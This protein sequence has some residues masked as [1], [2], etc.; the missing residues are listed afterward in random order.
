[1]GFT[2]D[3][4]DQLVTYSAMTQLVCRASLVYDLLVRES[5]AELRARIE[6]KF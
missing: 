2:P 6:R 3:L 1:M 5:S 4:D